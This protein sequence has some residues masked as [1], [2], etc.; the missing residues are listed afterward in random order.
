[1]GITADIA[2]SKAKKLVAGIQSGF[3]HATETKNADGTVTMT[4][5]FTNGTNL[6]LT[7]PKPNDGEKGD[8]GASV[9]SA[10]VKNKH[11]ILTKD[12][13]TDIDCGV[14]PTSDYDDTELR[15]LI[16][17]KVDK[18]AGKSLVD[19]TE[20]ARLANVDNYDDTGVKNSIQTVANGLMASAG[21]SAD[22]KTIDIVTVG[23]AKKSIDVKPVIEH[24]NITELQD[25]D[26]SS[27]GNGKALVFNEATGKHEY[28]ATSG[29]DELVKMNSSGDAK[30]LSDLI[31]KVTVVNENGALKVKKLDG[32]EVTIEE[33]NYLKG[34]TMNV[35]DLVN[36]FANGGVKIID[37]PVATYA[38][39]LVYDKSALI[40]GISYLIYVLADETHDGSKTTYLIDKDSSNPSYFGFADNHRDFTTNPINLVTEITGKLG[41]SNIDTDALFALLSVDDTYKTETSTNNIFSTHGAK[42]LYDELVQAIGL[43]ANTSDL[44]THTCDTGIHVSSTE[45]ETWNK[46]VDK[47]DKSQIATTIDSTCT[48]NQ[49]ACAKSVNDNILDLKSELG[50]SEAVADLLE[51]ADKGLNTKRMCYWDGNTLNTPYKAGLTTATTGYAIFTSNS[52]AYC[53]IIC[54]A[55]GINKIYTLKKQVGKWDTVWEETLSNT[56][57][58]DV[59]NSSSS[60]NKIP[61]A[62]ALFNLI[63]SKISAASKVCVNLDEAIEPGYYQLAGSS[64][65]NNVYTDCWGIVHVV[66]NNASPNESWLWVWQI[67]YDNSRNRICYRRKITT[68]V[69]WS[70]WKFLNSTSVDDVEKTA[71]TITDE[72]NYKIANPAYSWYMVENG[73]CEF[74]IYIQAVSPISSTPVYIDG[75]NLPAPK[76]APFINAYSNTSNND[77]SRVVFRIESDGRIGFNMGVAGNLYCFRGSYKVAES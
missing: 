76:Y 40:E 24:A 18:E 10:S 70:K 28:S 42:A 21:Y 45:K 49:V 65:I 67:V 11:L 31:D 62:K 59:I 2:Y 75:I 8:D 43:K 68:S 6:P 37:T 54:F 1:M 46:V 64:T 12:D 29:T 66:T 5:Y 23:G 72:T 58:T 56:S 41:T 69:T 17:D 26:D 55:T 30:Y 14:L 36:L 38:D 35:M 39:L 34:L 3:D 20:I 7:F 48:N 61:S 52:N 16:V 33:I 19:D 77:V 27:K 57:I 71:I 4:M 73:W 51:E 44:T 15:G 25:V 13:G 32:Q 22:Y 53:T 63:N 47:V 60:D 9:I 50:K 74:S